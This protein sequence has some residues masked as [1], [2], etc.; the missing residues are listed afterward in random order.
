M[1]LGLMGIGPVIAW[2]KASPR[3]LRR[4]FTAPVLAGLLVGAGLWVGG[5]R[6]T[7]AL[8]T[9]ALGAF[10]LATVTIE[11]H[12]GARARAGIEGEGYGKALVHLVDR[13]RRRYGGYIAHV[14]LVFAFMGFAGKAYN[15]EKQV[16]LHPGES[17]EIAS[18]FGH[19][20]RLAYQDISWYTAT[21]MT[22]LIASFRVEKAG[23]PA[24]ILTA[25]QRAYNQ[26]EEMNTEVGIR[27]SWDEDLYL[28]FAGVD[29][30][31][32][33]LAGTNPRPATTF[34]VLVNP[35]VSWIWLGGFI[36]AVGTLIAMWP[37]AAAAQA[38]TARKP[39]V[40]VADRPLVEV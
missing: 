6:H 19:T 2:R 10:T 7:Q 3:N 25:E 37:T 33:V 11:F 5:I 35:L 22:K 23:K 16:V 9:F 26:R 4:N 34:R 13:N 14:G 32:A 15:V 27:R 31:S 21:N 12:K 38:S 29:D 24:G 17:V 18:P 36:T 30:A 39:V 8:L 40:V 1:L 20:Y 28:I